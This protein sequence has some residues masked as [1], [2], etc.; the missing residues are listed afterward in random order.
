[1]VDS[2]L[3]ISVVLATYNGA[4][5]LREQLESL[6]VQTRLPD[7]LVVSDDGSTDATAEVVAAFAEEA[8]FPVRFHRQPANLG[9]DQNF[10]SAFARATGDIVF[11][12]DQ[13][14]RW[15]AEK[16]ERMTALFEQQPGLGLAMCDARLVDERMRPTG[17]TIWSRFGFDRTLQDIV[18]NGD[19]FTVF[20]R[21]MPVYGC[22]IAVRRSLSSAY[23]PIPAGPTFDSWIGQITSVLAPVR[24]VREPLLD[25]RQHSAQVT[26][27]E[28]GSRLRRMLSMVGRSDALSVSAEL[29]RLE[30]V[31]GRLR[32]LPG[33]PARDR[34]E[35]VT[36]DRLRLTRRRVAARASLAR[37]V[38]LVLGGVLRGEYSR[39]AQ[40]LRSAAIDLLAR[41]QRVA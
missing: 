6:A 22:T 9:P 15:H 39:G 41:P 2:P 20:A 24:L 1:M 10:A 17:D 16:L 12:C 5:H 27:F 3:R 21:R 30:A 33:S 40:G 31:A 14:D 18:E 34:A 28:Q 26:G 13:D 29:V 11:S 32:E 4:Q 23:L 19:A 38:P 35:A 25:Y 37:R 7:E 8:S 36:V